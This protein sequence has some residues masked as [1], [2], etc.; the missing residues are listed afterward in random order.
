M[1]AVLYIV[2]LEYSLYSKLSCCIRFIH[3]YSV[4][5]PIGWLVSW[6]IMSTVEGQHL[7]DTC[8]FA[9]ALT[10]S[11]EPNICNSRVHNHYETFSRWGWYWYSWYFCF[12][13]THQAQEETENHITGTSQM[14]NFSQDDGQ[15][16]HLWINRSFWG[17]SLT[18]QILC[19]GW[20]V[21]LSLYMNWI[22]RGRVLTVGVCVCVCV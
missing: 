21:A 12:L 18:K 7:S 10:Q 1:K 8:E 17:T 5:N 6:L 9:G 19:S 4:R 15:Y 20:Y 11:I 22:C 2:I 14:Q 16:S 3:Y 13:S